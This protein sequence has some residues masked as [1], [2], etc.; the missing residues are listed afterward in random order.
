VLRKMLIEE[1]QLEAVIKLPSG[2]FRP[3][4]GVSTAILLFTKGG[5]TDNVFF[6]DVQADGKTL[7]DKRDKIGAEDDWQDL[8]L[9]RKAWPKWLA[10]SRKALA[11]G[12]SK[13]KQT[14]PF[15]DR[16]ANAFFVPKSEIEENA[17][18]LSINRYKEI[19]HAEEQ[20]DSPKII[21]GR[22]KK[23][24]AEIASDLNDLEAMLN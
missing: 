5:E 14:L 23:L 1:N 22:L 12:S 10:V 16:T 24:E 18:D 13:N 11:A 20:Y 4:A 17:F 3:Y 19:V 8:D 7:D 9:L 15:S 6:V 2:V 21:L